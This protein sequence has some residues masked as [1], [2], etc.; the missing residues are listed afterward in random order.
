MKNK[1]LFEKI[2]EK[3]NIRKGYNEFVNIVAFFVY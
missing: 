1:L 2:S 3:L